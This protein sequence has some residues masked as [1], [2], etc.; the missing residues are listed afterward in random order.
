MLE[1][2]DQENKTSRVAEIYERK[3]KI[4][5]AISSKSRLQVYF[6]QNQHII[7]FS[8]FANCY[9][10]KGAGTRMTWDVG[11]CCFPPRQSA[12]YCEQGKAQETT[13]N[14]LMCDCFL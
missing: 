2:K 12:L 6:N 4:L 8:L 10:D 5:G 14:I 9:N 13:L 1:H 11:H 3:K 7:F